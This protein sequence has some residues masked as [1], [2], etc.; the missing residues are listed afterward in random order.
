GIPIRAGVVSRLRGELVVQ[1]PRIRTTKRPLRL[2][3]ITIDITSGLL[4]VHPG[5]L[6]GVF[7]RDLLELRVDRRACPGE[8]R[9]LE[10]ELARVDPRLDDAGLG[11]AA[12]EQQ[13]PDLEL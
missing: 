8:D 7:E 13:P 10:A 2:L 3:G 1:F 4:D 12:C 6:F 9:H 11:R 5:N